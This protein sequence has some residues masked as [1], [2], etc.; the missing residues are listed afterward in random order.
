MRG[1]QIRWLMAA[2][3]GA[4]LGLG[5]S[6]G[7]AAAQKPDRGG[8]SSSASS[9][10]AAK[11]MTVIHIATS[12]TS[13]AA[14]KRIVTGF[15]MARHSA[16]AGRKTIVYL[17]GAAAKLATTG[18]SL[19]SEISG[20]LQLDKHFSSMKQNGIQVFAATTNVPGVKLNSGSFRSGVKPLSAVK[21]FQKMTP[22]TVVLSF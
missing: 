14:A 22:Q 18:L 4:L 8:S 16:Q 9:S 1:R 6:P 2:G 5:L 12:A 17:N 19:A 3:L 11:G 15:A 10:S 7:P 13:P 21:L 20:T